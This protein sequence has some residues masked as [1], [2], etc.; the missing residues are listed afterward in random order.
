MWLTAT[1][2]LSKPAVGQRPLPRFQITRVSSALAQGAFDP[3]RIR[4]IHLR[5]AQRIS[6]LGEHDKGVLSRLGL[7][8]LRYLMYPANFW[9]HKNHEM[10]LTAFGI[11]SHGGLA[12][13]YQAGL[14]RCN[15]RAARVADERSP[16]HEPGPIGSSF[17]GICPMPNWQH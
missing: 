13:G 3:E 12:V 11:A 2:S 7:A 17:P 16:C 10:L 15:G 5:M 14:H 1:A 8:P 6:P 9:K 4:T